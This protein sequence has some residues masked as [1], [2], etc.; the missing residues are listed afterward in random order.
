MNGLR[1]CEEQ[2]R[3]SEENRLGSSPDKVTGQ[4]GRDGIAER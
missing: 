1:K 2:G 4:G 3:G